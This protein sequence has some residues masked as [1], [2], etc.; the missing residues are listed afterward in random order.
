MIFLHAL[1]SSAN[2]F[3]PFC[4]IS[5][6]FSCL[7]ALTQGSRTILN[8]IGDGKRSCLFLAYKGMALKHFILK[9]DVCCRLFIYLCIYLEK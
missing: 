2:K 9:C 6:P 1:I 3:I 7:P 4:L 5:I 8:R